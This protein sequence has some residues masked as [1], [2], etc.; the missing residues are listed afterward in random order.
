MAPLTQA[1]SLLRLPQPVLAG[2][3]VDPGKLPDVVGNDRV[4]EG[5]GVSGNEHVIA[6][7]RA[8]G[9]FESSTEKAIAGIGRRLERQ[10]SRAR[11]TVSS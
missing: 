10:T 9:M 3:I 11:S 7:D 6:A 1:G 8:A 2:K 5:R 4:A